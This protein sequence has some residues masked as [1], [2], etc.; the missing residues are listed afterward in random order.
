MSFFAHKYFN[1]HW[2]DVCR[3]KTAKEH[4][5]LFNLPKERGFA[6]SFVC[7]MLSSSEIDEISFHLAAF[8]TYFFNLFVI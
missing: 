7:N 4:G 8:M 3:L 6:S 1:N 2:Y 5:I